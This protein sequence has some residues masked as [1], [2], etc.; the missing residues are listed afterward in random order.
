MINIVVKNIVDMKVDAIVNAANSNLWMGGGVCGAIFNAAG[1]Q[2]LSS[3]C[4]EIGHCDTGKAV[5]TDGFKL[6]R[7]IVHA[8]GP[9]YVDGKHDEEK[10]L[11]ACYRNALDL[12]KQNGYPK[13]DAWRVAIE[14]VCNWLKD[15]DDCMDVYFAVLSE[16]DKNIGDKFIDEYL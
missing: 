8:V 2:E 6:S 13:I 16:N 14:S 15:N 11:Y 3:A 1:A 12:A 5:I 9:V 4:R 10:L 7:Y